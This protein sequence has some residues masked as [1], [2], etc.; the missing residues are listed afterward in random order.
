MG[1]DRRQKGITTMKTSTVSVRFHYDFAAK[2]IWGTKASF[3]KA[4]KGFG[5]VYEELAEKMAKQPTFKC[6]VKAPAK[7]A[8][9][10]KTY[11]GMD[12]SFML[13]FLTATEDYITLNTLNDVI[14]YAKAMGKSKYPLAKRVFF[15]TY[16]EF[17]YADAKAVVDDF[18]HKR[19]LEKAA[20]ITLSAVAETKGTDEV[21]LT[22]LAN[23]VNF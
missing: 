14:A 3:D 1:G 13:D 2:T 18:R 6:V 9:P 10:K 8:K 12:I 16:S 5:P 7:P 11:K 20:S 21:E 19:M 22:D 23:A 4:S 17:D 15:D